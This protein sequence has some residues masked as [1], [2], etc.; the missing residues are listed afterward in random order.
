LV[1]AV[2]LYIILRTATNNYLWIANKPKPI[3]I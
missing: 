3:P 2:A 1:M